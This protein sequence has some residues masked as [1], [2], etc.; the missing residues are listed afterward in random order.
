[1]FDIGFAEILVLAVITMVV[2]G[3]EKLPGVIRTVGKTVGQARRF[4]TGLQNQIE[5]EL[6]LDELN[7][8]IMADTKDMDFLKNNENPTHETEDAETPSIAPKKEELPE[9]PAMASNPTDEEE[10]TNDS[11]RP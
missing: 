6:R 7:K 3:P 5:Q 2:V 10:K 1:M 8:K 4:M 9:P 11:D